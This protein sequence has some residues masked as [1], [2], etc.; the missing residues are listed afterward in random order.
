MCALP[1]GS[2][3]E[4]LLQRCFYRMTQCGMFL[5]VTSSGRMHF[6]V[7]VGGEGAG[8]SAYDSTAKQGHR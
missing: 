6:H 1:D 8:E 7:L 4:Q 2:F 5:Y 3:M